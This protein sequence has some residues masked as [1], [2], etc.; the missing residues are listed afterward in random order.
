MVRENENDGE[1]DDDDHVQEVM[2]KHVGRHDDS[3]RRP[4]PHGTH[5]QLALQQLTCHDR[6]SSSI[7]SFVSTDET[8]HDCPWV[9][10]AVGVS[11]SGDDGTTYS[12]TL[13]ARDGSQWAQ[14]PQGTHRAE[15]R[16]VRGADHDCG[17]VNERQLMMARFF[18]VGG[19]LI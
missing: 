3:K 11:A 9:P 8:M 10:P 7:R 17:Q 14:R 15:R 5:G 2:Y 4:Q 16:N 19:E 12:H 13:P 18:L 1:D 6:S